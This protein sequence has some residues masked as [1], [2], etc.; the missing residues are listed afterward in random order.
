VLSRTYDIIQ[1]QQ[2]VLKAGDHFS[3][4]THLTE[5]RKCELFLG[6]IRP[7]LSKPPAGVA[8]PY[9]QE[10]K[11][12]IESQV[13]PEKFPKDFLVPHREPDSECPQCGGT[14]KK[15]TISGRSSYFCSL[16]QEKLN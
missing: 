7:K 13:D 6:I 12:A 1:S 16:H 5:L 4:E 8:K 3:L 9:L 14:I 10:M 15:A 2:L 11:K